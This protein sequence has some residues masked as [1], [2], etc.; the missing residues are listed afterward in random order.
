MQHLQELYQDQRG[1][2]ILEVLAASIVLMVAIL[3]LAGAFGQGRQVI[4]TSNRLTLATE[5]AQQKMDQLRLDQANGTALSTIQTTYNNS[6]FSSSA[7][8]SGI[9]FSGTVVAGYATLD[10]S[11]V[12]T[13]SG[14]PTN[15]LDIIITVVWPER[16]YDRT[17]TQVTTVNREVKLN[18]LL[19]E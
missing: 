18:S 2:S 19:T 4:E 16:V 7:S 15:M 5:L 1:F 3:S 17:T 10:A 11:G 14:S 13:P 12:V 6:T 9:T 8:T